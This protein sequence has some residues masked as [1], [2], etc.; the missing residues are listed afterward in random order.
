[1]DNILELLEE[2]SDLEPSGIYNLNR[3]AFD[4]LTFE[5][6]KSLTH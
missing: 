4:K 5:Y 6:E 2:E 1:M 3:H